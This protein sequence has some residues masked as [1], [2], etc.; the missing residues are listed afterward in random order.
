MVLDSKNDWLIEYDMKVTG[1]AAKVVL[2]RSDQNVNTANQYN[3]GVRGST[4]TLSIINVKANNT[5][6]NT[7]ER[8]LTVSLDTSKYYHV[9]ITKQN[10]NITIN[11]DNED[12]VTITPSYLNNQG[13]IFQ[14]AT[15]A[16]GN[17]GYIKNLKI[18]QS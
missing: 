9:I 1:G 14:L 3:F 17:A 2:L 15:W 8:A 13:F 7:G 6:D 16:N 4:G 10:G 12:S 11:V 18:K 5:A